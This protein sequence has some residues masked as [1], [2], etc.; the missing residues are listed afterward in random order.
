MEFCVC[1]SMKVN[2]NC[3]SKNCPC[4]IKSA[5]LAT[6]KQTSF[7]QSLK[8]ELNDTEEVNYQILTKNEARKIINILMAR[9][10]IGDKNEP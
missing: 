10:E 2:G 4:H 9:K 1:G 3:T 7:I 6:F 8:A 5:E